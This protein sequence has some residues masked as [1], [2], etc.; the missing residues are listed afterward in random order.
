MFKKNKKQCEA[1]DYVGK[2]IDQQG[3]I[4]KIVEDQRAAIKQLQK[5]I[6]ELNKLIEKCES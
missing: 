1:F 2:L 3:D 6:D 5:S 4:L